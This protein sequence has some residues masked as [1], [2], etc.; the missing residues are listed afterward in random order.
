MELRRLPIL[1]PAMR[2][3]GIE[4]HRE[5]SDE[6]HHNDP[7]HQHVQL[8]DILRAFRCR[9]PY[10]PRISRGYKGRESGQQGAAC[11]RFQPVSHRFPFLPAPWPRSQSVVRGLL[12]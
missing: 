3:H 4:H 10:V 6:D 2:K 12:E 11:P 8:E 5:D 7:H 9:R 1:G